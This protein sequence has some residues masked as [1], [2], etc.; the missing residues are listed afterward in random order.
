MVSHKIDRYLTKLISDN[1]C[2]NRSDA[3]VNIQSY[4][5]IKEDLD[6]DLTHLEQ[7][8]YIQP[9]V[10][11]FFIDPHHNLVLQY[12]LASNIYVRRKHFM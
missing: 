12:P 9:H 6:I 11:H 5:S 1:K 10:Y 2:K 8:N 4:L 7:I 3:F